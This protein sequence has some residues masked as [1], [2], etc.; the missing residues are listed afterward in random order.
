MSWYFNAALPTLRAV[1]ISCAGIIKNTTIN[2]Q[3]IVVKP[4][5][6]RAGSG[7]GEISIITFCQSC[8]ALSA[9]TQS[10]SY[11]VSLWSKDAKPDVPLR[12]DLRIILKR[13]VE[14]GRFKIFQWY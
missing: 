9:E 4:F 12:V 8:S 13:L 14:A 3:V 11:A 2:D 1:E 6:H 7:S 10:Y 5:V